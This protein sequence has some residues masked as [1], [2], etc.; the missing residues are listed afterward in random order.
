[1]SET[2]IPTMSLRFVEKPMPIAGTGMV[3]TVKT[4][5]VLQQMFE[6]PNGGRIWKNVPFV[7][8]T[9]GDAK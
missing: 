7:S 2:L 4:I 3:H 8:E 6:R 5:R 1:M 9:E